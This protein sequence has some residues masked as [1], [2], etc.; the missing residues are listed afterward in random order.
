M[1]RAIES[2]YVNDTTFVAD[3]GATSH[4]VIST[5]YLTDITQITSEITTGNEDRF[6]CTEKGIFRGFFKNKH[7]QDVPKVLQDVLRVP[8]LAVNLL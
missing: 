2:G 5:K 6:Q 1:V 7:G 8:W 4:M 3:T